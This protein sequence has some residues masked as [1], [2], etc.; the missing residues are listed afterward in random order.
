MKF[1]S[2]I[3]LLLALIILFTIAFKPLPTMALG[4]SCD[5]ALIKSLK[6][7]K[8]DYQTELK[9][10]PTSHKA[11]LVQEIKRLTKEIKKQEELCKKTSS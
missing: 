8:V 10:A 4:S 1:L 2:R 3:I 7:E 11:F 5:P 6:S 9:Q